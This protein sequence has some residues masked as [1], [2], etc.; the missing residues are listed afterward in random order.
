[1][2][3]TSTF[4]FA[5]TSNMSFNVTPT[6]V[7]P[8]SS[9]AKIE[10]E[11]T[12]TVL[13]N[14]TCPLDQGELLSYKA[15]AVKSVSTT[16]VIQNPAPVTNGVQYVVKLEEI[17]RTTDSAGNIICDEPVIA[18]LTI[19]HQASGNISNDIVASVVKR[20]IGACMREDG[21]WRFDDLMRSA[22]SPVAD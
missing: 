13:S 8:V 3:K 5:N 7:K 18:Y 2:S 4:A 21:T 11:P 19:R 1:M 17:L 20:C 6:D 14:K 16:Q 12:S 10:D 15:Q 9:Y 22:L